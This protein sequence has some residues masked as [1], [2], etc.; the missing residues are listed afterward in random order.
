MRTKVRLE[1]EQ[2]QPT[3]HMSLSHPLVGAPR[4]MQ[5]GDTALMYAAEYDKCDTV[6]LLV[7]R[8]AD[9]NIGNSVSLIIECLT[10]TANTN[11]N[12]DP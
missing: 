8:K 1:I 2:C 5:C 7:T 10:P 4:H 6:R 11:P 12:P 3:C 9:P